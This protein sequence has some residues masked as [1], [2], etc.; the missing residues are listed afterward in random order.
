MGSES[1]KRMNNWKGHTD[2]IADNG[3]YTTFVTSLMI[4]GKVSSVQNFWG[5]FVTSGSRGNHMTNHLSSFPPPFDPPSLLFVFVSEKASLIL[6]WNK[7]DH[8]FRRQPRWQRKGSVDI[9]VKDTE[10]HGYELGR[11]SRQKPWLQV[12]QFPVS[13]HSTYHPPCFKQLD[14]VMKVVRTPDND[15]FLT[16]KGW[17]GN[18]KECKGTEDKIFVF[19]L[20]PRQYGL[21][22]E[23]EMT[24]YKYLKD[25]AVTTLQGKEYDGLARIFERVH[26]GAMPQ[27]VDRRF[28]QAIK[29]YMGPTCGMR[30]P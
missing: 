1:V 23:E 12:R 3:V 20:H 13:G 26:C 2:G 18:G 14:E 25:G 9:T 10:K 22:S 6:Q 29:R 27:L 17:E 15:S 5:K 4:F 21:L 7:S 16:M 30:R 19:I 28:E 24:D 8:W 11:E